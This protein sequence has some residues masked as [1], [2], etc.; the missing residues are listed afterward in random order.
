MVSL[1]EPQTANAAELSIRVALPVL[2]T[3][4]VSPLPLMLAGPLNTDHV[5]GPAPLA[6]KVSATLPMQWYSVSGLAT[7][8]LA[9]KGQNAKSLCTGLK[10]EDVITV[11]LTVLPLINPSNKPALPPQ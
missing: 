9:P 8:T 5:C 11:K 7:D 2:L 1:S 4:T 6:C 10:P 3:V